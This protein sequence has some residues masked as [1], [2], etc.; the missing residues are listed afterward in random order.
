[1]KL[2][3]LLI[4]SYYLP[5]GVSGKVHPAVSPNGRSCCPYSPTL[6]HRCVTCHSNSVTYDGCV[7]AR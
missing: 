4:L 5:K 1:M 2:S 7:C 6:L 3:W